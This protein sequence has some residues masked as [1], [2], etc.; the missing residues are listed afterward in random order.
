MNPINPPGGA[1]RFRRDKIIL[2]ASA[3]LLAAMVPSFASCADS[4]Q[5]EAPSED[6]STTLG[7]TSIDAGSDAAADV[8]VDS[9]CSPSDPN[10]VSHVLSCD[11]A[12]WCPVPTTV[13][14]LYSLT[15]I[16]GS[17]K[18]DVWAVGS[19]GT[20]IHY[21]GTAWKKT[22]TD[23]A[24]LNTFRGV[25]GS[26]PNDVWVV[27]MTDVIFHTTGFA[28]G[29]A[30]WTR[31]PGPGA[32]LPEQRTATTVW[33]T[34]AD[35]VRIGFLPRFL[36]D[37]GPG[38]YN[39]WVKTAEPDGGAKWSVS[40]GD[41]YIHA[42]WGTANDLWYVADNS[43]ANG[44]QRGMTVHGT[45]GARG[46][47]EWVAVESQSTSRLEGIW[48]SGP[49]DIWAVGDN[50]TIRHLVN[51]ASRWDIVPS[52]TTEALHGIWG[53]GPNDVWAV[54]DNGTILRFDGSSWKKSTAA[55]A[56]GKKPR[57]AAIWGSGPNDVWIVGDAV[58]L[59]Y[60]GPKPGVQET[61]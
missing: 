51:G 61:E 31:E 30:T 34:S 45:P 44:W 48:G 58:A 4:E 14:T 60:T 43:E 57:L 1:P 40:R 21:D 23:P 19:G 5:T 2:G 28:N 49:N 17:S 6:A 10:C 22:P 55:F 32:A 53:S 20:I 35:D 18:S 42:F 8:E 12:A 54:G 39:Q 3:L 15:A 27:S 47:M 46:E 9:G 33:G 59:H 36:F 16:W 50:G 7:E 41:G 11:E 24:I 25:W 13:S 37:P 52:P 38:T 26:G 29:T 56:I